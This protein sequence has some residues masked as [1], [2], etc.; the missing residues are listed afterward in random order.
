MS[1][2]VLAL[3]CLLAP[4]VAF[5]VALIGFRKSHM[6]A[7]AVVLFSGA[8]CVLSSVLLLIK[9][10]EPAVVISTRWITVAGV[11]V[12][13]GAL[14]DGRTLVM[15]TVV[16]IITLCI[17]VY[18]LNYMATDPGRGRFFAFLALFEWAMLCFVYSPTLLQTFVFWELVGLA[19]FF[20]IGFWYR[21]PAAIAAAKK[22]FIMTRIG[23]VGLFIGLLLLFQSAGTLDILS[24]N[25]QTFDSG[26]INLITMLL[27][28]GIIGKSAQ[29]PLHTWLPDAMEGP[30]PVSA[31]LHSATMVAAGV[32]LFARFH[33]VFMQAEMTLSVVLAIA[34]FTAVLSSTMAMV[35][36]DMKRVLA[37]SSIS[38]LGFM[39]MGLAAG[40]LYA[41]FFHLT[42][43]AIF[44]ALLFL[45][46]G[47]YIHHYETNDLIAI[48]RAGGRKMRV[49]TAGLCIGGAALAGIPPLA[50]F[51]SKELIIGS[52]S[53][54][55]L[56]GAYAATFMTAYYTFRMIF[57]VVL[58]K[59]DSAARPDQPASDAHHGPAAAPWQMR[60]PI[61]LLTIGA[62]LAGYF[63]ATPIASLLLTVV[64]H[65]GI[66]EMA[67]AIAIAFAGVAVAWF[68]FGRPGAAQRGFLSY[69]PAL[70]NL[71]IQGWHFDAI[72]QRLF[73]K[74]SFK[75]ASLLLGVEHV[76]FDRAAD[77][78]ADVTM[79]SAESV[80]QSQA[81]RLQVYVGA[82]VVVLAGAC[83]FLG[84]K[85]MA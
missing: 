75:L 66:A 45:C 81:G 39:L 84:W 64:H 40:S 61:I 60:A 31:L 5:F 23:D 13:F 20:L 82:A 10:A 33:N 53:G 63:G 21:K 18:S 30:T 8:L 49:T 42:T 1:H 27:F 67:P 47:A 15:G 3:V 44:K 34:T 37:Y 57:F 54:V 73:V 19:S 80:A 59:A 4:L 28:V 36:K 43:H 25:E 77:D 16:A 55:F 26:S 24:L 68:D 72:Y 71:F 17:Q 38:Q 51:W 56:I 83:L 48:G 7:I 14:L 32:F 69:L 12:H 79:L 11:D 6:G 41:G 74:P 76:G 50:G 22:A 58:P 78:V 46:A 62:A 65:P 2:E 9:G 29:F 52:L 85:A 70:E 35:A